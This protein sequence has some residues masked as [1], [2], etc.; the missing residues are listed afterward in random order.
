VANFEGCNIHDNTVTGYVCLLWTLTS[1]LRGSQSGSQGGGVNVYG[2]AN[3]EGCNIHDNT[4]DYVCL[5]CSAA[6][7]L[8]SSQGAGLHISGTATLINSNVYENEAV[9][10]VCSLFEPSVT[11]YPSPLWSLTSLC[12]AARRAVAS[13]SG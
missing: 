2:V 1:L 11:F 5:K 12:L 8:V 10:Y 3:F 6:C 13:V 9:G 7:L 4:A